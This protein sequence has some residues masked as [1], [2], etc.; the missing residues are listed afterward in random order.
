MSVRL[1]TE[2]DTIDALGSDVRELAAGWV[3]VRHYG[4]HD[5]LMHNKFA[6]VDGRNLLIGSFNFTRAT[7]EKTKRNECHFHV[8][9]RPSDTV[10][11]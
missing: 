11:T 1:I 2:T 8:R 3:L 9:S 5:L 4:D 7:I 6:I 10:S